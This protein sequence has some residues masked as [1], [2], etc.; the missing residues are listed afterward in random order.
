MEHYHTGRALCLLCPLYISFSLM[1]HYRQPWS[2]PRT[3]LL[4]YFWGGKAD[5]GRANLTLWLTGFRLPVWRVSL[6]I[7]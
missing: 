7:G 6:G 4:G 1:V 5:L 2:D 3:L